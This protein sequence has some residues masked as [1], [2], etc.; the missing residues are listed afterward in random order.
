MESLES[1]GASLS[2]MESRASVLH[3]HDRLVSLVDTAQTLTVAEYGIPDFMA[4]QNGQSALKLAY[5][6][7][8]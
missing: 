6:P 2:H 5:L 4:N 3:R 8:V 7:V 1:H